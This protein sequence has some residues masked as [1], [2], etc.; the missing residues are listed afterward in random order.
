ME[1]TTM[2]TISLE[3]YDELIDLS[4]KHFYLTN[5]IK[6][7]IEESEFIYDLNRFNELIKRIGSF[8]QLVK[9]AYDQKVKELSE[10]E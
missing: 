4:N 9:K 1:E 7:V 6:Q 3:T 10:S 8:E 5:A 2:I